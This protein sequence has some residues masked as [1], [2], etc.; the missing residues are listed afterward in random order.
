MRSR[1]I[2]P[3]LALALAV[4]A[5]GGYP[6]GKPLDAST[7]KQAA[8]GTG[9]VLDSV[10]GISLPLIG[11]L[12]DVNIDQAVITN[13]A[14]VE[15]TV[16]QIVGLEVDGVLQLTGGVLGT[17][18]ITE[19]FTTTASVTSSGPGQCNLVTIDLGQI[20]IGAPLGASVKVPAA[21][22]TA[23]GSGAVGSLLCNLGN[24]LGGLTSGTGAP[25]GA[26]GIV[27][28]LNNLI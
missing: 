28:A 17:D 24:L 27:N 22:L 4:G 26:G 7:Q 15:T 3:T 5:C 13:F 23:K 10:T 11:K 2:V 12:G 14:L 21:T 25:A 18:V 19:N 20:S 6:S 8:K 9:L 16:G 1:R